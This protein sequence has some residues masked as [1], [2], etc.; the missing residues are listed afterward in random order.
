LGAALVLASAMMILLVEIS[1]NEAK[2]G[3]Q[4]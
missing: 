1:N 2:C 3:A 4:I